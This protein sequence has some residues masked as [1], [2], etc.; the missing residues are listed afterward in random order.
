MDLACIHDPEYLLKAADT[1]IE[2]LLISRDPDP[3]L[4]FAC[5]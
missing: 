5:D 3:M 2:Y 4:Y 1:I